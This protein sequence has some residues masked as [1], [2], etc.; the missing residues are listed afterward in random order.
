MRLVAGDEDD[1]CTGVQHIQ[2]S[3]Q[4]VD[5]CVAVELQGVVLSH[6]AL[7]A[8]GRIEH[9]DVDPPEH[10]LRRA[11]HV[12]HGGAV[13]EVCSGDERADPE[14]RQLVRELLG[15]RSLVAV[16]DDDVRAG[17]GEVAHGVRTD[18]AGRPRDQGGLPVER[19]GGEDLGHEYSLNV[20][21]RAIA[22]EL[23]AIKWSPRPRGARP[24]DSFL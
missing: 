1:A 23:H 14:L 4:R 11:E 21:G 13:G 7:H 24:S 10:V 19:A 3:R 2:R 9:E 18:A 5:L 8:A 20:C 12:G 15:P 22:Q 6:A 16:V 17:L